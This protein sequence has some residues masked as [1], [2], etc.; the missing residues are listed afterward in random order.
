M[1]SSPRAARSNANSSFPQTI[2]CVRGVT[3]DCVQDDAVVV[4][5]EVPPV[6]PGLHTTK[7]T[8]R[9]VGC[10]GANDPPSAGDAAQNVPA[11]RRRMD[12]RA[13]GADRRRPVV[14]TGPID[15][16]SDG[17]GAAWELSVAVAPSAVACWSG[18]PVACR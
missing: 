7:V 12:S 11:S 9:H 10:G 3:W 1:T 5:V 16:G 15:A 8:V 18:A 17:E 2:E 4:D 6:L 14:G 13:M